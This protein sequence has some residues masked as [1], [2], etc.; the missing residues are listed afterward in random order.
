MRTFP[1]A[2]LKVGGVVPRLLVSLTIISVLYLHCG[3]GSD[4]GQTP[5]GDIANSRS[6]DVNAAP[7]GVEEQANTA[8]GQAC[9]LYQRGTEPAAN[10]MCTWLKNFYSAY[11]TDPN[12]TPTAFAKQ[13]GAPCGGGG[14]SST[15]TVTFDSQGGSA[16][17][18][19][20]VVPPATTVDLLPAPP[21]KTGYA[22]GGWYSAPNGVGTS[23]LGNTTVSASITVYAKW[24]VAAPG[25]TWTQRTLPVAYT[26]VS[27]AYGNGL[28]VAVASDTGL[29]ITS[30]DG[31]TW[32]TRATP[33]G[34]LR[35]VTYGN[36]VFVA[37]QIGNSCVTSTNGITWTTRTMP[38]SSVWAS[39]A[40]GNGVFTAVSSGVSAASAT[41][42]D[43][44]NW[45][46]GTLPSAATW[47]SVTYGNG[48]FLALDYASTSAATSTNGLT[49]TARTLPNA[50][51]KSVIFGNGIFVAV[52]ANN[53]FPAATSPDGITWTTRTMP[54]VAN[55]QS[56]AFGNGVFVAMA[57][58]NIAATSSDG[59]AWTETTP[60]NSTSWL[61]TY[62][63][64]KFVAVSES[65]QTA[66]TS[67]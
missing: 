60:P 48:I 59:I 21:T 34:S 54:R 22:F 4:A 14:G 66:A 41:S 1:K 8:C 67:P 33:L 30:P 38:S 28:F 29:V 62:G 27:V 25:S 31:I 53:N 15:F 36:G 55:W 35:A 49:W 57:T 63:N 5:K 64:G 2:I 18:N 50:Y 16:V 37:L 11:G 10:S 17:T 44:I 6:C 58:G 32:T 13:C 52:A 56:V 45:T 9:L 47:L 19:K 39:V 43:G 26:W 46:G 12:I 42:P 24:S 51:L 7:Y 23:F 3:G 61:V 65:T 40:Y 20:V